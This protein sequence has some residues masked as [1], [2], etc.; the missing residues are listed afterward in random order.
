MSRISTSFERP[1]MMPDMLA[2]LREADIRCVADY[3]KSGLS[4]AILRRLRERR[5][6][7]TGDLRDWKNLLRPLPDRVFKNLFRFLPEHPDGNRSPLIT[8]FPKLNNH[9]NHRAAIFE[10]FGIGQAGIRLHDHQRQA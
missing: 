4:A 1:E 8:G 5:L 7:L 9:V 10:D 3:G 2:N 6:G